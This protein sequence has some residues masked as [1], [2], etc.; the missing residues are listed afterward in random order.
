MLITGTVKLLPTAYWLHSEGLL[1]EFPFPGLT[2][3][4]Q[5]P[6]LSPFHCA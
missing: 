3:H 5:I 2:S 4:F 1:Y 6:I